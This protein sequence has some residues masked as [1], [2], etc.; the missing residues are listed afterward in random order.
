MVDRWLLSAGLLG[1]AGAA[2]MLVHP[3]V[4][5]GIL[6]GTGLRTGVLFV[7]LAWT[8]AGLLVVCA[9]PR[10]RWAGAL[11]V[12]AAMLLPVPFHV[13]LPEWAGPTYPAAVLGAFAVT[14]LALAPAAA[15]LTGTG[16]GVVRRVAAAS[17]LVH[18]LL[19]WGPVPRYAAEEPAWAVMAGVGGLFFGLLAWGLGTAGSLLAASGAREAR[20]VGE[21]GAV[22]EASE[23]G[24]AGARRAGA[25]RHARAG[26]LLGV[27]LLLFAVGSLFT[28]PGT[29]LWA[30]LLLA[31]TAIL[32]AGVWTWTRPV[33]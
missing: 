5:V 2:A 8:G 29:L 28:L 6:G 32:A 24:K 19:V 13:L 18:A 25:G 31:V 20:A 15:R 11:T 12:T 1:L 17:G 22:G 9:L 23:V 4:S 33:A 7:L 10:E 16:A 27:A 26:L 30:A 21:A 3:D 14:H